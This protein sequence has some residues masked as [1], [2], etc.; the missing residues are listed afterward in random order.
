MLMQQLV[1][2]IPH[3][4]QPTMHAHIPAPM[5]QNYST[6]HA[7]THSYKNNV[8]SQHPS[9]LPCTQLA[10]NYDPSLTK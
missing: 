8:P 10:R 6:T 9:F 4:I 7:H 3:A 2:V 1:S 5:H